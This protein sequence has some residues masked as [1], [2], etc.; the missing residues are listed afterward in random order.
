MENCQ[1]KLLR[2][3]D[4]YAIARFGNRRFHK[5]LPQ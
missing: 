3:D 2:N 4:F 5:L 1:E